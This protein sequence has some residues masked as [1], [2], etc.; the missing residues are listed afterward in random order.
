MNDNFI[1]KRVAPLKASAIREIFKMVGQSDVISFAGGNPSAEIFPSAILSHLAEEILREYGSAALQYGV[2]EGYAPLRS[3]VSDEMKK[4]GIMKEYDECLI[5]TGGQQVIDLCAKSLINE[6][7]I[8]AVEAPS[9][10]GG[11]NALRSYGGNLVGIDVKD[12][13]IDTEALEDLAKREKIKLLYTIPTFQNPT[14]ITMSLKKREEVLRIAQKY[15]FY[16]LEDNPYG[17]LRFSG[18]DVATIKSLDKEGRVIYAS[19]YSKLISP[20]MRVGYGIVRNDIFDRMVVCK[21][22]SDVHT[23]CLTQMMVNKFIKE[24][25]FDSHIKKSIDMYKEKSSL[26][27]ECIEKYFPESCTH[28]TP[29]G[30][31]FLWCTLKGD[32]DTKAINTKCVEKKVVFVPGFTAMVDMNKTYNTFRLN[33]STPTLDEIER[34]MK[35]MGEVLKSE[36]KEI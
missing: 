19:S 2:T 31:I 35:I 16:I 21:Q 10:I 9:F 3:L 17:K 25:D 22:V 29:E 26:M 4:E 18:E 20:G 34:G 1:A 7:D 8:V 13:G 24:Y 23:P 33:Y 27:L 30:G 14:G 36:G 12:D 32:V 11:L 28:T 5:T 6:G 15:D